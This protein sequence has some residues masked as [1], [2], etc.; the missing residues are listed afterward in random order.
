MNV[1]DSNTDRERY[2]NH[3]FTQ[4]GAKILE[5]YLRT[6]IK[7]KLKKEPFAIKQ[8]IILGLPLM[9]YAQLINSEEELNGRISLLGQ[10]LALKE[11]DI[12][13]VKISIER[14]Q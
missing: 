2:L 7:L 6:L 11:I 8:G 9:A 1:I 14:T 10:I 4:E 5:N 13:V 12:D 3:T